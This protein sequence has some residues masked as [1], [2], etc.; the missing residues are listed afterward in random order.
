SISDS[1]PTDVETATYGF[2]PSSTSA[3]PRGDFV[4]QVQLDSSGNRQVTWNYTIDDA[5]L[6]SMTE[7]VSVQE[8]YRVWLTD[9]HGG[10]TAP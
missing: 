7:G 3:V 10:K 9:Q 5:A 8:T 2:V 1:D 6:Q 4:A